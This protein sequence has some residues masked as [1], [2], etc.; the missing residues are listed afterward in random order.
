MKKFTVENET[1][2]KDFTDGVYPQGSFC[3]AAL[4]REKDVKVNGVRVSKNINLHA[5][6]EVLYY[7]TAKQESMPSHEKV[8]EDENIY[9]A[10]KFSG[11]SFEGL[12]CELSAKGEFYGVHRL[13]RNTQGLI[14]FAKNKCAEEELLDG[15]EKRLISKTYIALCKNCFKSKA[16]SL[17]AYL[18]KDEKKGEVKIFRSSQPQGVTVKTDY[19]ILE[20]RGDV[21]LVEIILHTG[22]THQIRAHT[23]FIGCPVLG[24]TKYGDKAL[25][26]KYGAKRQR[27]VA[28]YLKF[29]LDGKLAYLNSMKFESKFQL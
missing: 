23:A 22:R 19:K 1:N 2:L 17:T 16:E 4:L 28:K 12:L 26:E 24:D 27:L 7:T 20:E 13:D 3:L 5:G 15:F 29:N 18:V 14:V 25:N 11:V 8:F 9:I 10:D 6:D 21:A